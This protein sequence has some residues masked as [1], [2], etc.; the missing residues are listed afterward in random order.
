VL[1]KVNTLQHIAGVLAER[2]KQVIEKQNVFNH[3][4]RLWI[5]FEEGLAPLEL[6]RC[7]I[8]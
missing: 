2:K 6:P 3:L 4:R 8:V 5:A 7:S 1:T